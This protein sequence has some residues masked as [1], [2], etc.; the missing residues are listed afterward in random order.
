MLNLIVQN[1][2]ND[3][4]QRLESTAQ[5][6]KYLVNKNSASIVKMLSTGKS[7]DKIIMLKILTVA[8]Q[9]DREIGH[10][11]LRNIS[12]FSKTTENKGDLSIFEEDAKAKKKVP[13]SDSVRRAFVNFIMS[14]LLRETDVVMCKKILQKRGLFEFF[15][16][17][18]YRDNYETIKDVLSCLTKNVLISPG[19]S[20]PEK[21]KFFTDDAIKHLLKLYEWK[22][23]IDEKENVVNLAHHFLILLL[24]NRKHGIAFKGLTENRQNSRQLQV[25]GLFKNVWMYEYPSLLAIE[26]IKA[27]PDLMQILLNRLAIGLLPKPTLHWFMCANFTKKLISE[28]D[29]TAIAKLIGTLD[30]KKISNNIIRFSVSQF[31]LQQLNENA[32]IQQE[33]LEIRE[34]STSLL[35]VMLMQCCKFLEELTKMDGLKDFEK[36]RIKFDLINHLFTFF[37]HIDIILNSL[38]RSIL[39]SKRNPTEENKK[40]VKSQ[41]KNTLE[42]LLL[43]IESFP[44]TIEKIPS[45]VD[46]LETLRQIYEYQLKSFSDENNQNES[47]D[48]EMKI[49][50][51]IL[52][53]QPNILS[54][55]TPFFDRIFG[56]MIQIHCSTNQEE[57]HSKSEA[58]TLLIRIIKN[59]PIFS[60]TGD[61]EISIWL[62]AFK[63]VE[64]GILKESINAFIRVLKSGNKSLNALKF[65]WNNE[66]VSKYNK[67]LF[68]EINNSET[69]I[70]DENKIN[71][72]LSYALP[73][74]LKTKSDKLNRI[75]EFVEILILLLYHSFPELK[76]SF[77]L[78]LKQE[79][80]ELNTN[81]LSYMKKKTLSSFNDALFGCKD[82]LYSN[83]QNSIIEQTEFFYKVEDV[84]KCQILILQAIFC[85]TRLAQNDLLTDENV[86]R[87]IKLIKTFFMKL[88]QTDKKDKKIFPANERIEKAANKIYGYDNVQYSANLA[89]YI[90]E[91]NTALLNSFN[92]NEMNQMTKFVEKLID[93]FKSTENFC[94]NLKS[95]S[96]K[97]IT[98]LSEVDNLNESVLTFIEKFPFNCHQ[99]HELITIILEKEASESLMQ[100]LK[101][102]INKISDLK[103][104]PLS[105]QQIVKIENIYV[106]LL[107]ST[108][109]DLNEFE[110]SFRNYFTIYPHCM[111][112]ISC[113]IFEIAFQDSAPSK[114]YLQLIMLLFNH[115]NEWNEDFIKNGLQIKKEFLFPLLKIAFAK[116]IIRDEML[117]PIYAEFKSGIVRA[118]EKPNKAAQIYREN[119]ESSLKLI[120]RA[121]PQNECRDLAT[122]KFK[123]ESTAAFQIKMLHAVYQKAFENNEDKADQF[124]YNFI[125]H[126]IQLFG[127]AESKDY[128]E[129]TLM[130]T[131]WLE[132]EPKD[133]ENNGDIKL[134]PES[135]NKFY[136]A[137][138]K[139]GL[140]TFENSEML[141]IL[142]KV[143][144]VVSMDPKE[145]A[146]IFDLIFTHSNFFN[147]AFNAKSSM[148]KWKRNLYFL[149]NVLVQKNP[150]VAHEK[151]IPIYLSSYQATMSSCDQLILNLLRFYEIR[152]GIDLH[153]Y[154]PLLFGQAAL[155]HFTS[156]EHDELKFVKNTSLDKM[157]AV[158]FKLL[159]LFEKSTIENTLNNYPIERQLAGINLN[160]LSELL[161]I[162]GN[163]NVYDPGYFLPLFEMILTTSSFNFLSIAVKNELIA[164]IPPALSC[165]DENMRLLAAH[166]LLKCRENTEGK[167]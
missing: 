112:D 23:A 69:K 89:G 150:D 120:S 5:A 50:K 79:D 126:W 84:D 99:Y 48:I 155:S 97:I 98:Q 115:K 54:T 11:I 103:S 45:V 28:I 132:Y 93:V 58:K 16:Q 39:F 52:S 17:G 87:L 167:K 6:L 37:P 20:K 55:E 102:C 145:I 71:L 51:I 118:I 141:V 56:I 148:R 125:Y 117:K 63:S 38:Y 83:F 61:L 10:D 30:A 8:V 157:D 101:I 33:N 140:K 76:K 108:P 70:S 106:H 1:I 15:L 158:F 134:H 32:L 21:L 137:C 53:L 68:D 159:N 74:L 24:T 124:F 116:D 80:L 166:V 96:S 90:F 59:I 94:A 153:D 88:L 151:H 81:I 127:L 77:I 111:A 136:T 119:I 73:L 142:G 154:S 13:S 27:C 2:I 100:G 34:I 9:I 92:M 44:A 114:S 86:E 147:L 152:C 14:F 91:H 113:K 46:Y 160:Q 35:H 143:T 110:Q 22:G 25:L 75:V 163:D 78:L 47:L 36:H 161:K 12:T 57:C 95:F 49:I 123:F 18:L 40:L 3:E 144:A 133:K 146:T 67:S 149:L 105:T 128:D 129:F 165:E 72:Q 42:I 107:H 138:L 64:A 43:L 65:K 121:M 60:T 7:S 162:D 131:K 26:I 66:H 156:H 4:N 82:L 104:N 19:F 41:L 109:Y 139:N 130:M 85:T 62:E 164:L 122:K 29:P 135:W 31:I